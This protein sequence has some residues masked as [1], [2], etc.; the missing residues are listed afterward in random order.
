MGTMNLPATMERMPYGNEDYP[1]IQQFVESQ[2]KPACM[3]KWNMFTTFDQVQYKYEFP[4]QKCEHVLVKTCT[5]DVPQMDVMVKD[6]NDMKH[7]RIVLDRSEIVIKPR[8]FDAVPQVMI[9][10][11]TRTISSS[12]QESNQSTLPNGMNIEFMWMRETNL[13]LF[14]QGIRNGIKIGSKPNNIRAIVQLFI[15]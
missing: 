15:W 4:N 10:R 2:Q 13:I 1:F 9:N 6:F 14:Q 3:H 12:R 8:R 11:Q 5:K 7:I